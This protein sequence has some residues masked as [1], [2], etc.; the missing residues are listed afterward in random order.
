[1]AYSSLHVIAG[2]AVIVVA[3]TIFNPAFHISGGPPQ[4]I[5]VWLQ[6]L[7]IFVGL[8]LLAKAAG[9]FI[10]GWALLQRE[11]WARTMALVMGFIALLNIPLG[12]ALGVYTLWVLLPSQ[13]DEEYKA[14]S[15]AA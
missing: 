10:A 6:P 7:I 1:M 3:K 14:I 2:V 15:Q 8:L 4:E 9:G 11:E 5:T 13:S 12:T